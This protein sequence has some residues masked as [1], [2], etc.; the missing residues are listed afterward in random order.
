MEEFINQCELIID[1]VEGSRIEYKFPNHLSVLG[2]RRKYMK[3][4]LTYSVR[5]LS[6]TPTA[7]TATTAAPTT[8]AEPVVPIVPEPVTNNSQAMMN[9]ANSVEKPF[10]P[11]TAHV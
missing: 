3:G 5:K 10:D 4:S 7:A 1:D 6:L 2:T 11:T 9:N 8:T